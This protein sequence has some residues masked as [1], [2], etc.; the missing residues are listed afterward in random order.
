MVLFAAG[1][2]PA[3]LAL[4]VDYFLA[5]D[6]PTDDPVAA[7]DAFVGFLDL[8]LTLSTTFGPLVNN[9]IY[10]WSID[11]AVPGLVFFWTATLSTTSLILVTSVG[12]F[13]K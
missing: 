9:A 2:Y 10:F 8:I 1:A 3:I 7:R 11:H 5:Q 6:R 12:L 13:F 4:N